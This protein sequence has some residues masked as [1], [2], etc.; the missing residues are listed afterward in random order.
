MAAREDRAAAKVGAQRL[1]RE[2]DGTKLGVRGRIAGLRYFVDGLGNDPPV[3][4]DQRAKRTAALLRIRIGERDRFAQI[5][6]TVFHERGIPV[7][8]SSLRQCHDLWS[9]G[10][11][12]KQFFGGF[13]QTLA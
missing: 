11:A 2:P 5:F 7:G 6:F 4:A 3:T 12:P 13:G 9:A 10:N 8:W 1:A